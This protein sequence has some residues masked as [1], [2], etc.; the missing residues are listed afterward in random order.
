VGFL[1]GGGGGELRW[2]LSILAVQE[3]NNNYLELS[4]YYMQNK[5]YLKSN[6]DAF[7]NN[8]KNTI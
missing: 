5:K 6:K 3:R 1:A 8:A 2:V 7:G 4:N